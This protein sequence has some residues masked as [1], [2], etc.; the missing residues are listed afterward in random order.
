MALAAVRASVI[1][2]IIS[3]QHLRLTADQAAKR[4]DEYIKFMQLKADHRRVQLSPSRAIDQVW[5]S[6]SLDTHSYQQLQRLLM[7][8]GIFLHYHPVDESPYHEQCYAS[9]LSYLLERYGKLDTDCWPIDSAEYKKL[10]IMVTSD[11]H[12]HAA[13]AG[14]QIYCHKKQYISQLAYMI[15]VFMDYTPEYHFIITGMSFDRLHRSTQQSSSNRH[16]AVRYSACDF[17]WRLY[18]C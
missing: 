11:E 2:I 16:M 5:R 14:P 13:T 12:L 4:A 1:Q 18:R 17:N 7:P 10:N 9:T 15:R 3:K 8:E 6:H